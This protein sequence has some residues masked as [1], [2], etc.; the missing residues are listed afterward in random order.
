[1]LRMA[2]KKN[3]CDLSRKIALV[4]GS[5]RGIGKGIA[6]ALARAG[7]DVVLCDINKES[8][9]ETCREIIEMGRKSLS[10]KIDLRNKDEIINMIEKI[11]ENFGRIDVAFNNSGT[12]GFSASQLTSSEDIEEDIFKK[13]FESYLLSYFL[14]C[15]VEAKVMIKQNFG[16]II[17]ISSV[18][19]TRVPKGLKGMA[20][21][22]AF[23]AGVTHM[24][25]ALAYEWAKYNVIVNSISPG[26][27]ITPNNIAIIPLR[28]KMYIEQTPLGRIGLVEDLEG[29][30]VF[31]AS[32]SSNFITGQDLIV[33]GGL[34][35]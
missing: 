10:F 13:L 7:A 24:V 22:C 5:G 19:G 16:K 12:T 4:T 33:D 23:K 25:K 32:D 26:Y 29:M 11:V 14:C 15:Q 20:P 18:A 34:I 2:K 9:D 1:M 30:A 6:L 27:T 17:C 35:I 21:Y 3:Y 8:A 31:L 28:E